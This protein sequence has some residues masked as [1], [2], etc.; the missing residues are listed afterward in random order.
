MKLTTQ[1]YGRFLVHGVKNFT[2]TYFSE[3]VAGLQHDSVWRFLNGSKLRS[4]VIWEKAKQDIVYS[5]QG[6]LIFDNSVLYKSYN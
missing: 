5:K 6:Y 4:K 3:I 1:M 2:V